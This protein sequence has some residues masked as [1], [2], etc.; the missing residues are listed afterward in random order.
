V[1][2]GNKIERHSLMNHSL[3]MKKLFLIPFLLPI[4]CQAQNFFFSARGGVAGYSGDLKQHAITLSQAKLVGSI[5]ARYDLNEHLSA[6]VYFSYGSLGASDAKR[7]DSL[8]SRNLSFQTKL[9][10]FE[11]GAQYNILNLNEH[12]WT[13]YV[14]AGAG[15][16][17]YNPYTKAANGDKVFLKPLSTEGEGFI[18]GVNN[19]KPWQFCIPFGIGADYSLDEDN[20][21]GVEFGFRKT[22]TDYID[23]VSTSYVDQSALAN[24]RGIQA[25]SLAWRGTGPYPPAGTPRG[26]ASKKDNYYFITLTYTFRFYFDKYKQT[27]GIPGARKEKRVGCPATHF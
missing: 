3:S 2:N 20:K 10:D 9:L 25:V 18:P 19:Y 23:D 4:F 12:W 5:G 16:F 8:R 22:F 7:K 21:I 24:A 26:N 11:L 13:P 1:S 6:R 17:H 27:S 14:F 15:F